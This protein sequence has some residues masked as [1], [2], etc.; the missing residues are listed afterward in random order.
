MCGNILM[1]RFDPEKPY[2]TEGGSFWTNSTSSFLGSTTEED[3]LTRTRNVCNL[4]G[5]ESM[6]L[7][8]I[9]FEGDIL[10]LIQLNDKQK[11]RFNKEFITHMEKVAQS[12]GIVI[13]GATQHKKFQETMIRHTAIFESIQDPV[14]IIDVD[15]FTIISSNEATHHWAL[16]HG[17]KLTSDTCH[18]LL[19]GNRMPCEL[20]GESCP[21][22]SMMEKETGTTSI[23]VRLDGNGERIYLEESANPIRDEK[24]NIT[25][26]VLMV[27]DITDK[28]LAEKNL[29]RFL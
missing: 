15:D 18:G 24:R 7:I 27:R 14:L 9:R 8:P 5:Y 21:L 22:L 20:Y 2:F 16:R 1:G 17:A 13:G 28:Q 6:A 26:A 23:T 4:E 29:I 19:A 10:G 11:N 3:R 12:I 25:G